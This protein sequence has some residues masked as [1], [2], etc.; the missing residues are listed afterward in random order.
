M[1]PNN[2]YKFIDNDEQHLHTL[3]LAPLLGTT[4]IVGIIAKPLTWWASGKAVSELGWTNGKIKNKPVPIEQRLAIALPMLESIKTMDVN[5]YLKLLDKAY[6]AHSKSLNKSAQQGKDLHSELERYIKNQILTKDKTK[7]VDKTEYDPK[8]KP[9]IDWAKENVKEF[10]WSEGYC[11]SEIMWTGGGCDA[12]CIL[13]N[14]E[15]AII[16]F[17]SSA[18]AYES[19]Y[20]QIG[21]YD[22]QIKENG[23]FDREGTK[24]YDLGDNNIAQHIVVPFRSEPVLPVVS[25]SV[26]TNK[27]GFRA[28]LQLYKVINKL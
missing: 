9:F 6:A 8:I 12:G 27:T 15:Y 18:E 5:E 11:Y 13:K 22:I 23:V 1:E 10:L 3:D 17:K 25:K 26:E 19:H 14:G 4:S 2:R 21:G 24:I 28:A 7:W 16:D 20:I